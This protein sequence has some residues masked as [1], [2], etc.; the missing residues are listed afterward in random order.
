[1][2][3]IYFATK[4]KGKVDFVTKMLSKYEIEVIHIPIGLPE[5]KTD[6]ICEIARH[7][8]LAAYDRLKEPVIAL[9]SGFYIYSLNGFPGSNAKSAL[10]KYGVD[11]ILRLGGGKLRECE[12]RHCLAYYDGKVAEPKLF[13]FKAEG[14]LS[15]EA[16]GKVQNYHWSELV[17]VF[18]PIGETKT[19]AEMSREGY[20]EWSA[21]RYENR[22]G[23]FAGWVSKRRK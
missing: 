12:F 14:T 3:K 17:R 20:Q 9:D 15:T 18:V 7:K 10:K 2:I 1:M 13:G 23:E 19:L 4:N 11:G 21:R 6:N 16:R 5:P 8:V 22:F